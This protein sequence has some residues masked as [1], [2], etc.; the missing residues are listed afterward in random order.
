M[1]KPTLL[2]VPLLCILFACQG[3]PPGQGTST[4]SNPLPVTVAEQPLPAV[5]FTLDNGNTVAIFELG[6]TVAVREMGYAGDATRAPTVPT[7]VARKDFL[8]RHDYVSLFSLVLPGAEVPQA[9]LDLQARHP[10]DAP[11]TVLT[12]SERLASLVHPQQTGGGEP[13][14]GPAQL[15]YQY[16]PSISPEQPIPNTWC[17]NGCC[18]DSWTSN[19]CEQNNYWDSPDTWFYPQY[20]WS[21]YST[22]GTHEWD[23]MICT[24]QGTSS[25][26]VQTASNSGQP[27]IWVGV[28]QA[29]WADWDLI[30]AGTCG[31]GN[32]C[33]AFAVTSSVNTS[34]NQA[35][36]TYCGGLTW[37]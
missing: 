15:D 14:S 16:A 30:G 26:K 4:Q 18:S 21:T 11:A 10:V 20:G 5:A 6:D 34:S 25:W 36:H 8:R 27:E 37:N 17:G 9:L 13:F 28:P 2:F 12:S 33:Q 35:D 24:I 23:S 31:N 29:Q 19:L 3:A 32:F 22:S 1:M 7:F